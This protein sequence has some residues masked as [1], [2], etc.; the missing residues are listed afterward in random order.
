[1]SK[2]VRFSDDNLAPQ[3]LVK[4]DEEPS[5]SKVSKL[6]LIFLHNNF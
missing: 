4:Y 1:M 2:R 6:H 5:S 3:K